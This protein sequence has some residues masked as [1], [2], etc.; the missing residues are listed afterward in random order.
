MQSTC[1]EE[2]RGR[3]GSVYNGIGLFY[4]GVERIWNVGESIEWNIW[5]R[6]IF[7]MVGQYGNDTLPKDLG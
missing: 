3:I 2:T 6:E 7:M 4:S 1:G 5:K